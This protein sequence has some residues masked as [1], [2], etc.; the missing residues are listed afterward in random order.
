VAKLISRLS[1]LADHI[2]E[3]VSLALHDTADFILTLI[4][5]YAPV[6]TGWLRDSYKKES[7]AQLH[8]LI[9][10]MVNYALFV[11]FGT[12]KA[13]AQPHITPAFH[14]AREFFWKMVIIRAEELAYK[15]RV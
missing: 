13:G 8:I 9:G 12:H 5:L 4:R 10:T 1:F 2:D 3:A 7:V 15:A 11:E 6:Q 14:Q